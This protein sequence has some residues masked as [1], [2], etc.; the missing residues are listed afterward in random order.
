MTLPPFDIQPKVPQVTHPPVKFK[1]RPNGAPAVLGP[2]SI[3]IRTDRTPTRIIDHEL[4]V[5]MVR[6][7]SGTDHIKIEWSATGADGKVFT[8]NEAHVSKP[9]TGTAHEVTYR[10][11]RVFRDESAAAYRRE[12]SRGISGRRGVSYI[13]TVTPVY[14]PGQVDDREELRRQLG[15]LQANHKAVLD[16]LNAIVKAGGQPTGQGLIFS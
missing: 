11:M 9:G 4:T 1:I 14:H 7:A 3:A 12:A 13:L 15:A 10:H 2:W 16:A 6:F 5:S 8:L